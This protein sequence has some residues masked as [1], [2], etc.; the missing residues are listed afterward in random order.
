MVRGSDEKE[1]I[2]LAASRRIACAVIERAVT[3][4]TQDKSPRDRLEAVA[5][6]LS[7][8]KEGYSFLYL[9]EQLD[10]GRGVEEKIRAK[11]VNYN[12]EWARLLCFSAKQN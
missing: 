3:D 7:E 2:T 4:A 6:I 1:M 10:L 9:V 8:R 11:V 12:K 5:W